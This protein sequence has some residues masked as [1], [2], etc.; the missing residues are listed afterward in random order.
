MQRSNQTPNERQS[1]RSL[2]KGAVIGAAGTTGIVVAGAALLPHAASSVHAASASARLAAATCTPDKPQ[3]ILNIAATAEQ[4]A[5]TFYTNGI[6]NAKALTISGQ[7]LSYLTGAVEEEQYHLNVLLAAGAKPLTGTFSFPDGANTFTHLHKF[8]KTLDM[9]ETAFESAYI[10]A[11]RD[12]VLLNAPDFAV[13]SAQ[14]ATIEA[15]HRAL[16]RSIDATINTANNWAFTPVY[17]KSVGD[18]VNVLSA[19]GFLSPVTGNSYQYAPASLSQNTN[20]YQTTP[21]VVACS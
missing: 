14:I 2:L 3:D 10:A 18:A 4:L 9:L 12:F 19:E 1:R 17:V 16:G 7:N 21:Y 5:V 6:Q 8:I 15:E 20:V 13:L 11:I